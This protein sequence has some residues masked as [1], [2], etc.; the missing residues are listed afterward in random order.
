MYPP[1]PYAT[2]AGFGPIARTVTDAALMLSVVSRPDAR[3]CDS[4]PYDPIEYE[5][6]L[7]ADP[8]TWRIAFSPARADVAAPTGTPECRP[9]A[10]IRSGKRS[11]THAAIAAPADSPAR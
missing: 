3:D 11:A 8:A 1:T 9:T 4:L 7:A 6:N 5:N 10:A 2:L